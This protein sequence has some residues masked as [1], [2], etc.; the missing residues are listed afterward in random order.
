MRPAL[1][2]VGLA[3]AGWLGNY[4]HLPLFFG[5]DFLFGSI[6]SLLAL[7]WC[8]VGGGVFVTLVASSYTYILWS[9]PYAAIILLCETLVVGWGV[10][11]S[12]HLVPI[13]MLYW[14]LLGIPLVFLCYAGILKIGLAET[15][16]IALKQAV[17][18]VTN[19][20]IASFVLAVSSSMGGTGKRAN[21]TTLALEQLAFDLLVAFAFFP[22]LA[23]VYWNGRMDV[24]QVET[25]VRQ[26]LRM[27][28][29]A[30][31]TFIQSWRQ[32]HGQI[33]QGLAAIASPRPN[34]A[35]V[36]AAMDNARQ[37][38]PHLHAICLTDGQGTIVA[39]SPKTDING[40]AMVGKNVSNNS[41][42]QAVRRDR[43]L[44][45][46]DAHKPYARSP[47]IYLAAPI[48]YG[49]NEVGVVLAEIDVSPLT[50]A[51]AAQG[52]IWQTEIILRDR[53]QRVI[54]S[55]S[56]LPWMSRFTADA[57]GQLQALGGDLQLWQPSPKQGVPTMKR[58]ADSFYVLE[59]PLDGLPWSIVLRLSPKPYIAALN[60][61]YTRNL[62]MLLALAVVAVAIARVLGRRLSLPLLQL[63]RMT[64][65]LPSRLLEGSPL[66][67][68]RSPVREVEVL[69]RN[70]QIMAE[71]LQEKFGEIQQAN[72]ELEA[73]VRERTTDLQAAREAADAANRAKSEFLAM[74]SHEIRTPMNA[75]V[76]LAGL[77]LDSGGLSQQQ[78]EWLE[79][80]RT[81]SDS[82]LAIVNDIL[83]FSKIEAGKLSL[84]TQEF[85]P[86]GC[87]EECLDLFVAKA[88]A[89]GIELVLTVDPTTPTRIGADLTRL[90]QV[91]VNLIGNA[92]KFTEKG[93]V[94]VTVAAERLADAWQLQFAIAD[95]GIGI[96]R[97][98]LDR[99]FEPFAQ[100]DASTTR[101]Y[102]GTGLGLTIAR[103]LVTLMG[104]HLWVESEEG[105]GSTFWFT[106]RA[107]IPPEAPPPSDE[108]KSLAGKCALVV[109]GS[110]LSR[111]ALVLL[112]RRLGM[113]VHAMPSLTE[114]L[115]CLEAGQPCDVCLLD[116]QA[117]VPSP[118]L[119][120]EAVA[121]L[122]Q[123]GNGTP[124]PAIAIA[125]PTFPLEGF[126][127]APFAAVLTKPIKQLRLQQVLVDV[128]SAGVTPS[129]PAL[130]VSSA[131][132]PHHD[133]EFAQ[134]FPL[135]ILLAEDNAVNQKVATLMLSRLGYRVDVAAN[136]MEVLAA[137]HR[138][139]YDLILMDVQMP[140]M[141]GIAATRCIHATW[142]PL[143]R[144]RI[145]AMTANATDRDRDECL[146][147]GMDDYLSKP[148]RQEALKEVLQRNAIAL[149]RHV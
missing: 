4:L 145:V 131:P 142:E 34:A 12:Q 141:D 52:K 69:A 103:R 13:V 15:L 83:D 122:H 137:L 11:R 54:A 61:M 96:P 112:G 136:G 35:I 98:R 127:G 66:V 58:W 114:A 126:D 56:K 123:P 119:I 10:R 106:I 7:H 40:E 62:G 36:Q 89:K 21:G 18:G 120:S 81:S 88:N 57:N 65:D 100:G 109:G 49:S 2:L 87:L 102:G 14:L 148:V 124:I 71:L 63:A 43:R 16:T 51:I 108:E 138:Q 79:I 91:L 9:H 77:L 73:R 45:S 1:L 132:P 75:I 144:P 93:N 128:F 46:G 117:L 92:I 20:S 64:T 111:H 41:L 27:E 104:G 74:M 105:K 97:D 139:P 44:A 42:W 68:P 59:R 130:P 28:T 19:A 55:S 26:Q 101:K 8:G 146:A 78:R 50:V 121:P 110:A 147:A 38:S 3:L 129:Y 116:L 85:D 6:A 90:R 24:Q 60:A 125:P 47:Y 99:L 22:L 37:L 82:L 5:V 53:Q 113:Q 143:Q 84:E 70:A 32:E 115:A 23:A 134:R 133:S 95:T 31:A 39:A 86:V 17:N 118:T 33:L 30:V 94:A 72:L 149:L 25:E 80:V 29:S 48:D 140:D 107:A 135:R 67:W 76:G